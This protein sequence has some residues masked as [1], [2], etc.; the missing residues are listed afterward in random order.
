MNQKQLPWPRVL[1]TP[2]SPP[3]RVASRLVIAS[4]RPVPPY[5]RVVETSACSKAWNSFSHCSGLMPM[6]VSSTSKRS[7]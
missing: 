1:L 2:A 7:R 3:I 4:P 5:L 6:P